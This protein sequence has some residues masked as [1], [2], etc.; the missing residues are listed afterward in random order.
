MYTLYN[1]DTSILLKNISLVKFTRNYIQD[2]RDVFSISSLV[3]ISVLSLISNLSLKL[4]LNWLVCDR[5]ILES[6]LESLWQS[7]AIFGNLHKFTEHG[8]QHS[9]DLDNKKNITCYFED[10]NFTCMFLWH[11]QYRTH[12][13][14][15]LMRYCSCH[16]NI[17]FISSHH[18][19]ISSVSWASL[20]RVYSIN[21]IILQDR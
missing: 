10:M 16:S 9:H 2:L 5:N 3:R 1:I 4:Y 18:H 17:K 6:F 8:R 7:S 13:L 19:V 15:S 21:K 11:E 12:S 20:K 14:C